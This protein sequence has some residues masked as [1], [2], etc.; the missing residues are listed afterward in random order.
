MLEV[1]LSRT[2]DEQMPSD[3]TV[4]GRADSFNTFFSGTNCDSDD[5]CHRARWC[6]A[7]DQKDVQIQHTERVVDI[8]ECAQDCDSCCHARLVFLKPVTN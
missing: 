7:R 6:E 3:K 4:H 8:P 1:L 5:D 2:R